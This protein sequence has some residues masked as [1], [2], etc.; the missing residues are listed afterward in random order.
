MSGASEDVF[1]V[2]RS[3]APKCGAP[4]AVFHVEPAGCVVDLFHSGHPAEV[5]RMPWGG[6]IRG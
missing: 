6:S 5:D 4:D 1:H 3:G 2:E